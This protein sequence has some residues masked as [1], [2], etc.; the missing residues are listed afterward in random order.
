MKISG[1][2]KVTVVVGLI[3]AAY[4]FSGA[5]DYKE[6]QKNYPSNFASFEEIDNEIGCGS[7]YS[8]DKKR[9]IFNSNYKNHWMTWK[10]EVVLVS[11][12]EVSLN[13]DGKGTQDLSV[14]FEEKNAGY[15][16]IKGKFITVQFLMKHSGGCFLPFTGNHATI[17]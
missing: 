15:N 16:L 3:L 9:D 1:G 4:Y 14:D 6:P 5:S 8:D 10:G 2:T 17:Q 13:I 7:K 11:A 12:D